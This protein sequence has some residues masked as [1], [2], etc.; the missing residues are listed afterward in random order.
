MRFVQALVVQ[1]QA[2]CNMSKLALNSNDFAGC[3]ACLCILA[4]S[5]HAGILKVLSMVHDLRGEKTI[6]FND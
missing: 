3:G 1:E 2:C 6:N 5:N 4:L